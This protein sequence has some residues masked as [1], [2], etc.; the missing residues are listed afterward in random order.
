MK[1]HGLLEHFRFSV[2]VRFRFAAVQQKSKVQTETMQCQTN[3]AGD[4]RRVPPPWLAFEPHSG[5]GWPIP[6]CFLQTIWQGTTRQLNQKKSVPPGKSNMHFQDLRCQHDIFSCTKY[7][8]QTRENDSPA[9]GLPPKSG[10]SVARNRDQSCSLAWA[11]LEVPRVE[12]GRDDVRRGWV[13]SSELRI[14]RKP[15][16]EGHVPGPPPAHSCSKKQA[17]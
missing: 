11:S 12:A 15:C 17:H 14:G 4:D 6:G 9:R 3:G 7:D 1:Y 8:S 16:A 5:L 2:K 13:E 10:G